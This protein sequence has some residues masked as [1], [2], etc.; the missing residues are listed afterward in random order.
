MQGTVECLHTPAFPSSRPAVDRPTRDAISRSGRQAAAL[1][2]V[3][4]SLMSKTSS[5]TEEHL[6]KA[7]C[8]SPR[9]GTSR[10][11]IRGRSGDFET[12]KGGVE[13]VFSKNARIPVE[14]RVRR[15]K[16]VGVFMAHVRQSPMWTRQ[17]NDT[18]PLDKSNGVQ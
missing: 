10:W 6:W 18:P 7:A 9:V 11:I 14:A 12:K 16:F 4:R 2:S 3:L 17:R 15:S 13:S 8:R 5:T 1:G